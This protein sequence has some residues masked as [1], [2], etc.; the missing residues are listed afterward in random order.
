MEKTE[1]T[2]SQV[3]A[4]NAANLKLLQAQREL[5]EIVDVV[6]E[7][8][9]VDVKNEKW[10]LSKDMKFLEKRMDVVLKSDEK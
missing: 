5:Q 1:L 7:E 4:V 2:K 9:K 8:L 3:Y 6:A 10:A